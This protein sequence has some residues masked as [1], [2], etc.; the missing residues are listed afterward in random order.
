MTPKDVEEVVV[1]HCGSYKFIVAEVTDENGRMKLVVRAN[2]E[3]EYHMNIL[4]MLREEVRP[5]GFNA[6]C[7]GGGR[8]KIN[9]NKKTICIWDYSVGF[10]KEPDRRQTVRMLQA[11]FPN[12]QVAVVGG[13]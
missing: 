3:C 9:R 11:A 5:S 6:R 1:D 10:G 4:T 8:I 7:I 2:Q 12:F 13:H